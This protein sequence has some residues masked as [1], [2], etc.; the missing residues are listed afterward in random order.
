MNSEKSKTEK[1]TDFEIEFKPLSNILSK[2]DNI[3]TVV[4][5]NNTIAFIPEDFK[6]NFP[7]LLKNSTLNNSLK[8]EDSFD[9]SR[10]TVLLL[11]CIKELKKEIET[12]KNK[13]PPQEI[14]IDNLTTDKLY[15]KK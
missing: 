2:I 7:E 5:K 6:E 12:L 4:Y 8:K 10:V 11:N 13:E 9:Y 3:R 14:Y 15:V 1:E